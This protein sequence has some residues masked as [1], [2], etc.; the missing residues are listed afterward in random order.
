VDIGHDG[1][2]AEALGVRRVP[3]FIFYSGGKE[4]RRSSGNLT[5]DEIRYL[6]RSPS[7]WF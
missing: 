1:S 6:F 4:I 3:T 5:C 7:S 2:R